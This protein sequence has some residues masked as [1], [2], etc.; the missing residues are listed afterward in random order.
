ML[1]NFS[2]FYFFLIILRITI[3]CFYIVSWLK[4]E[5]I[6]FACGRIILWQSVFE[7]DS[8]FLQASSVESNWTILNEQWNGKAKGKKEQIG[9]NNNNSNN[10][11]K[12]KIFFDRHYYRVVF[13]HFQN[14]F[15]FKKILE[16]N[17]RRAIFFFWW[18]FS[19]K[20]KSLMN[21][22]D[23]IVEWV[24]LNFLTQTS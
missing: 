15:A 12:K 3:R 11:E 9:N 7:S 24:L 19:K 6:K 16:W 2:Y 14:L 4:S 10:K 21:S 20:K 5:V 8:S 1:K 17:F 22:F 18:K 23:A 13:I